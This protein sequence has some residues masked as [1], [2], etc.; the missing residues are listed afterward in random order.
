MKRR[1]F[2]IWIW[3]HEPAA[4][5]IGKDGNCS[6][7]PNLVNS[8]DESLRPP[9]IVC[10]GLLIKPMNSIRS[11][12]GTNDMAKRL[13]SDKLMVFRATPLADLSA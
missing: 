5:G 7:S 13:S 2:F 11:S 9:I 4:K 3:R 12:K 6:K 10:I 8:A 1:R